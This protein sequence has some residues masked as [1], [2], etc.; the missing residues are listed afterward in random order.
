MGLQAGAFSIVIETLLSGRSELPFTTFLIL[1]QPIHLVIGIV[2]GLLTGAVV[3]FV[4]KASPEV[5]E[6]AEK[7]EALGNIS[8][9]KFL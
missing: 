7:G 9:K 4:L 8:V 2:E 3:S 5:I 6:K 1:M